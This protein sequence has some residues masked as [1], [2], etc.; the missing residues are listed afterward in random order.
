[1]ELESD[2]TLNLPYY[3]DLEKIFNFMKTQNSVELLFKFPYSLCDHTSRLVS[4]IS[5]LDVLTGTYQRSKNEP[6]LAHTLNYDKKRNL[7]IDLT[8]GQF[9]FKFDK[10]FIEPVIDS[11]FTPYSQVTSK[12]KIDETTKMIKPKLDELINAY[13]TLI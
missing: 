2:Q 12:Y 8:R 10:I 5:G 3:E 4:E 7:Y 6:I 9:G 13:K 1:M 11:N